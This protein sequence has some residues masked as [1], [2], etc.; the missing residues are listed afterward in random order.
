MV[1]V[2]GWGLLWLG[3]LCEYLCA[4]MSSCG[5]AFLVLVV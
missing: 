2:W 3:C 1:E 4:F 5:G